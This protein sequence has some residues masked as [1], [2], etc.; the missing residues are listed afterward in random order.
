V[1]REAVAAAAAAMSGGSDGEPKASH[2]TLVSA[3][4]TMAVWL[5][6]LCFVPE[7]RNSGRWRHVLL[8]GA[9]VLR[10]KLVQYIESID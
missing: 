3:V 4:C 7:H 9:G 8:P 1:A 6:C 2:C 10:C 5:G